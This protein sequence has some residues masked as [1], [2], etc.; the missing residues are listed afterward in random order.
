M[1]WTS[2]SHCRADAW[3]A[4]RGSR[5]I[6]G[7]LGELGEFCAEREDECVVWA[8][9]ESAALADRVVKQQ[10]RIFHASGFA[11]VELRLDE[12]ALDVLFGDALPGF[13]R[14]VAEERE[15]AGGVVEFKARRAEEIADESEPADECEGAQ[16]ENPE[17][18]PFGVGG[19]F[20]EV[21]SG[22]GKAS[23]KHDE[24]DLPEEH[25]VLQRFT[26]EQ[27]ALI[28]DFEFVFEGELADER[29]ISK[30]FERHGLD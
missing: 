24:N 4:S 13:A 22:G 16:E 10:H 18:L 21:P 29:L 15:F 9:A 25:N 2:A 26:D 3:R 12:E 17:E 20:N 28:D 27:A 7:A 14:A 23:A 30:S 5:A 11:A 19:I 1:S 8:G 6:E